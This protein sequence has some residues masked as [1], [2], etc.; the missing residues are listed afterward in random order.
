MERHWNR[1]GRY[2]RLGEKEKTSNVNKTTT[3]RYTWKLTHGSYWIGIGKPNMAGNYSA[4]MALG[5]EW[6]VRTTLAYRMPDERY[7]TG[8]GPKEQIALI[9]DEIL[10]S[11]FDAFSTPHQYQ[12]P[13]HRKQRRTNP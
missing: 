9:Q 8:P 13:K 6:A 1:D 5:D 3:E 2:W 7:N 11:Y 4:S 12:Q 10:L